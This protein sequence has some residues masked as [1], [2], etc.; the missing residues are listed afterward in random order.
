MS[1]ASPHITA[2][3]MGHGFRS[4]FFCGADLTQAIFLSFASKASMSGSESM[5]KETNGADSLSNVRLGSFLDMRK[6]LLLAIKRHQML[7]KF[8][9]QNVR[10]AAV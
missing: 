10:A 2:Q 8:R 4:F 6:R 5:G 3:K 7:L 1:H 9:V